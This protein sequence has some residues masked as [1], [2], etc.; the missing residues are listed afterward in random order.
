M[1]HVLR[2]TLA[3]LALPAGLAAQQPAPAAKPADTR[4]LITAAQQ[5]VDRYG[6]NITAA[7][8]EMPA[9]KYSF[10]AT[11]KQMSFG[12]TIAHVIE[13][14]NLFCAHVASLPEPTEKAPEATAPK[15]QLVAALQKSFEYCHDALGKVDE[16]KLGDEVPFW[17]DRK[18]SRAMLL[19][20]VTGDLFDHYSALAIYLRLNGLLPP[21]AQPR[22]A[23]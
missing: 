3:A 12:Q 8:N 14:N 16:S 17:G 10:K 11:E 22:P 23:S 4:P 20:A 21:T 19:L 15:E 18:A 7:A 13:S 6:K 9:D 2:F 1:K 5:I